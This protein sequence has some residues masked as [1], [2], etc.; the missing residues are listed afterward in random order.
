MLVSIT[1]ILVSHFNFLKLDSEIL[2][3]QCNEML[4]PESLL[5]LPRTGTV[6]P[7]I[8]TAFSKQCIFHSLNFLGRLRLQNIKCESCKN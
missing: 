1:G 6:F 7:H 3:G 4:N 5:L 2:L 8:L